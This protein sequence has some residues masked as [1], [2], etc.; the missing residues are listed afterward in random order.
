MSTDAQLPSLAYEVEQF[1]SARLRVHR[2]ALTGLG[3]ELAKTIVPKPSSAAVRAAGATVQR[4]VAD[5][6][7]LE[8]TALFRDT[9]AEGLAS[10]HESMVHALGLSAIG[11]IADAVGAPAGQPQDAAPDAALA[12]LERAYALVSPEPGE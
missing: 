8:A 5:R 11:Q 9:R 12:I 2:P 4:Y 10:F 7:L 6:T 3:A 1:V